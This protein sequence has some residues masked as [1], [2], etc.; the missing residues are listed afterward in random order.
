M[1]EIK[2]GFIKGKMNKD[3]DERLIPN[4][5]YRDAL[6]IDVDFSEGSD[7]GALKN[8]LG[9]TQKNAANGETGSLELTNA[10]CIG[11]IKDTENDK[12]YWFITSASKDMI[13]EY[14]VATEAIDAILVDTGSVLNFNTNNIITGVNILDG[15]LYF[16]DDLNEP[17]QV[18]IEYWR[19]KTAS[20]NQTTSTGLAADKITVIKKGPLKA[21]TLNMSSS[22]RGG[23]GTSGNPTVT[24][25]VTLGG[26]SSTGLVNSKDSGA[27]ISGTFVNSSGSNLFKANDIIVFKDEFTDPTDGDVTKIEAR[28]KLASNHTQ[29]ATTFTNAEILTI[30][31]R[32]V[33]A[34]RTYTCL[35]Q[36]DDPLFE[37]KFARFA[38]RYKYGVKESN[39]KVRG[40]QYST[41]SPFSN[42]A[43]IPDPT[44]GNNTGFEFNAESG[45]NLA[46]VNSLRSLTIEDLD[47]RI[48]ADVQE[49][50]VIYKDSVSNNVYIVDTIKRQSNGTIASTFTVK[51]EQIFKVLPSN[52]LLRIFDSVPKKAKAQDITANRLIY[53]N[54]VQNFDLLD[55]SNNPITPTFDIKLVNRYATDDIN[56]NQKQS[57]KSNRTYQ[58]GVVYSDEYGRQTPVLTDNS[59]IIKVPVGESKNMTKFS[60]AINSNPP[61]FATNYKYFIKEISKTTHNIVADSFYQDE[62]GYVYISMPS[63]EV[64]KIKA[65]DI[66]ILKKKSGNTFSDITTK[67][68]VLDKLTTPPDF[69]AKPMKISYRPDYF[70]FSLNF[71]ND[72]VNFINNQVIRPGATPVP[73]RNRITVN[74]MYKLGV[75]PAESKISSG[76]FSGDT[77]GVSK[78]AFAALAPGKFAQFV[79][80]NTKSDIYEVASIESNTDDNDDVEIHFVEEFGQD[81]TFIYEDYDSSLELNYAASDTTKIKEGVKLCAVE[82]IDES[83][84]PE[85]QGRFF[86]KIKAD[87]N[88]IEELK[89]TT[90]F[91]NLNA[92]STV[93]INGQDDNDPRNFQLRFGGKKLT[94]SSST[95][96]NTAA[97]SGGWD[98]WS[99]GSGYT[100]AAGFTTSKLAEG[101]HFAI[102]TDKPFNDSDSKYG[103]MPFVLGLKEGNYLQFDNSGAG[104]GSGTIVQDT[105][106]YKIEEVYQ[107]TRTT[108]D[109]VFAI[110]LDRQLQED[111]TFFSGTS[112][113]PEFSMTVFEYKDKSLVNIVNPPIFEIEP[114]DDVD[115]DIYY[116]TQESFSTEVKIS[117]S[118][119]ILASIGVDGG[120]PI[121]N[122]QNLVNKVTLSDND[123]DALRNETTGYEF[124]T[125]YFDNL[126]TGNVDHFKIMFFDTGDILKT[127]TIG[128]DDDNET[129]SFSNQ[130][131]IA[132]A[133]DHGLANNLSYFNC[134]SFENGVESSVIRDDFNAPAMGKGVR[135]STIFEDNYQE[136]RIKTGL[137]FSQIYNGKNGT[138]HLNQFII[139]EPI[140]KD[141]NPQYG[142]IQLLHTRY[143]DIIAYCE[144]KVLKILTNK[145]ALFNADGNANVTSNN[146]VLGQAI[147]YNSNYGIGT[148]PESFADFTYRG[149]FVDKKSGIVVRHSADGME[150]ISNFGM[151][152]YFRDNLRNQTGYMYGSYDEKKSQY[153]ITLPSV[154]NTTL[155]YSESVK[156][157]PSR[158]SFIQEGGVSI[159]GQ[160]FTFKN[161][162]IYKHHTGTR[163]TFYGTKTDS[164]VSFVFNEAPANIKNFRTLNYEGDTGWTCESIVTDQQDGSISSFIKKENK[165]FNYIS[166]VEET[167]ASAVDHEALNVQGIGTWSSNSNESGQIKKFN[168]ANSVP[169][170]LQKNDILYFVHPTTN[171]KTKIGPVTEVTSTSVSA[172]YSSTSQP[173]N[174]PPY[175]VYFV[176][177]AKF[178]TSGLLGYFAD[179]KMK[180][181]STD[182]KELYSVGSEISISS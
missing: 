98:Q 78:Q 67:F 50:D 159:N 94:Q 136:E 156:G 171:A 91:D 110:K 142:S 174:S 6:N 132:S 54:Y 173:G 170:D 158:K 10:T 76:S 180:N 164:E 162:N 157:W 72:N 154:V 23:S 74:R 107:A 147:P 129:L 130:T 176:K 143:N 51:D 141:L 127:M 145:D 119:D 28:L 149:Y 79:L 41:I 47:D 2:N 131:T 53:G 71:E 160:Y 93:L 115:I 167:T 84:K 96:I 104:S 1:P 151:K 177:N 117:N 40:N 86:I 73:N 30:S 11:K 165:Y 133:T 172:D 179:T 182:L 77:A 152:D 114:Q 63:S 168:F 140:T 85:F 8:I 108:G 153:N 111:L 65:D 166:G 113:S 122:Q 137:I 100:T 125:G 123:R 29:G 95:S 169:N 13:A 22:T 43:F 52:Q 62:Q 56:R 21:P 60:I 99:E 175:F 32:A 83:G 70:K 34:N 19:A 101:F 31:K 80:G 20:T 150:E 38:Y 92:I 155:S 124:E 44:V 163:N 14:D 138:N 120:H 12:I 49:I 97:S 88:L 134:F 68:K 146:A 48:S 35:L 112:A 64:N 7:V 9:N 55:S 59:G 42:V 109:Q 161:G 27:T 89:G 39:N 148:N 61:S 37:L 5:E 46:M 181:T 45:F 178:E 90:N 24:S 18:D 3:L 103:S 135:V 33:G 139:A 26:S 4:G 66:I 82:Q 15:V 87:D 144:D 106:Y 105:N 121:A 118:N 58:I 69:L 116:E 17:R 81:V 126:V 25:S 102:E 16:T 128:V 75:D 36:E 57:I